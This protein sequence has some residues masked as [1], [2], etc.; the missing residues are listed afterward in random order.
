V[1]EGTA[2]FVVAEEEYGA[3]PC[4]TLHKGIEDGRNRLL[5]F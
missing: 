4:W 2:G 1:G 5:A 3:R